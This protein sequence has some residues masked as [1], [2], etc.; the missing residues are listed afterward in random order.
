MTSFLKTSIET[1]VINTW[2]PNI[3][4]DIMYGFPLQV[5]NWICFLC[6][7]PNLIQYF[8]YKM[9][10]ILFEYW[11]M[12]NIPIILF[13]YKYFMVN[14]NYFLF[15]QLFSQL[16]IRSSLIIMCSN[17]T[18]CHQYQYQIYYIEILN[19]MFKIYS[20]FIKFSFQI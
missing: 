5:W 10:C 17:S 6:S 9:H 7:K 1:G 14:L 2:T 13:Q 20:I 18:F 19:N 15:I 16:K 3:N 12:I 8:S 11:M 4:D